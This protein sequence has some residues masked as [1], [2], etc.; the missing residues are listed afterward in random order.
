MDFA[1]G[2]QIWRPLGVLKDG[3]HIDFAALTA[4]HYVHRLFAYAVLL[5]LLLLAWRLRGGAAAL[6]AAAPAQA[7]QLSVA[8]Q[9]ATG[10]SNVILDWPL[11]AAVLHT[12][13]AAALVVV[14]TW[15]LDS[16]TAQGQ[17][18]GVAQGRAAGASGVRA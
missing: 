7:R 17:G 15:A 1:Q 8:L 3:S 13:G 5:V 18:A 12:G 4:I 14:L 9:L 6:R 16:S 11:V 2:F 10:L